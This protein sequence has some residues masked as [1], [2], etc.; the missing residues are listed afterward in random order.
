MFDR[1]KTNFTP[2]P[3]SEMFHQTTQTPTVVSPE[4]LQFLEQQLDNFPTIQGLV[5][6]KGVRPSTVFLPQT[7]KQLEQE[8]TLRQELLLECI[9]YMDIINLFSLTLYNDS[10]FL[11]SRLVPMIL[12]T[13]LNGSAELVLAKSAVDDFVFTSES[14]ATSFI[15]SNIWLV[16]IYMY[17]LI[18]T[19]FFKNN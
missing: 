17:S 18:C 7:L 4:L 5:T 2:E 3:K 14:E 15:E 6:S 13:R 12:Q 9:E 1:F 16:S 11:V 10:K 8:V 19:V